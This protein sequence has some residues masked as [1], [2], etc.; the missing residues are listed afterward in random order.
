MLF[1]DV[2][3]LVLRRMLDNS[4]EMYDAFDSNISAIRSISIES[5]GKGFF[6]RFKFETILKKFPIDVLFD[7]V[8]ENDGDTSRSY[9]FILYIKNGEFEMLECYTYG[10]N[11]DDDD[12]GI[13]F[14]DIENSPVRICS[15][16]KNGKF[17]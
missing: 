15:R 4:G 13:N 7:I 1:K 9:G 16:N 11:M 10:D 5:T 12:N 6:A 17:K 2:I 8:V 3:P 14:G